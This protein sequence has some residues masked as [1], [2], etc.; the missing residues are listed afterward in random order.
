MLFQR[1]E[2]LKS[3]KLP[4]LGNKRL[5]NELA[6]THRVVNHKNWCVQISRIFKFSVMPGL[7]ASTRR[8]RFAIG[9]VRNWNTS[10]SSTQTTIRLPGSHICLVLH[11]HLLLMSIFWCARAGQKIEHL[12]TYSRSNKWR[13]SQY[14]S[15]E[16]TPNPASPSRHLERAL[17]T[18]LT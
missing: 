18:I 16:Q 4:T 5:R 11:Y 7:S 15:A 2:R 10:V 14:T 8:N 9:V 12:M 6:L 1:E 13:S 17:R 3:L